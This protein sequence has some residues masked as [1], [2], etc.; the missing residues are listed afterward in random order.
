MGWAAGRLRNRAC[1][2]CVRVSRSWVYGVSNLE[3]ISCPL[4]FNKR[5]YRAN[6]LLK[7][8]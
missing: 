6:G 3:D 5:G 7:E 4:Q 8:N 2:L 1:V